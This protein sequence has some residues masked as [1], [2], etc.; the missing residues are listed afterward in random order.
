MNSSSGLEVHTI[1]TLYLTATPPGSYP[2]LL[3]TTS[4]RDSWKGGP[5]AHDNAVCTGTWLVDPE[6]PA[7]HSCVL[8]HGQDPPIR[9]LYLRFNFSKCER[10]VLK[11]G[12]PGWMMAIPHG[13]P[14]ITNG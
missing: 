10:F 2:S 7:R 4:L 5:N 1:T 9:L 8:I 12:V 11:C 3:S 6:Y 14:T 13:S